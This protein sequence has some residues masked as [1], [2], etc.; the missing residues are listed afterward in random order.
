MVPGPLAGCARAADAE[1][2]MA[3]DSMNG[4][5]EALD[6][7]PVEVTAAVCWGVEWALRRHTRKE[8]WPR[9][10]EA[11]FPGL[12]AQALLD[13]AHEVQVKIKEGR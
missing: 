2:V 4:L 10:W 3:M 12:K 1:L 9:S 11:G 6:G 13:F 7:L 5:I 8:E